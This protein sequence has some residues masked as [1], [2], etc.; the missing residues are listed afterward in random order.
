MKKIL[1]SLFIGCITLLSYSQQDNPECL[2]KTIPLFTPMEGFYV[3]WCK[4]SEFGS[5]DFPVDRGGGAITKEGIY[6]EI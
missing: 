3:D 4:Y 5:N 1:L 6:R 2:D